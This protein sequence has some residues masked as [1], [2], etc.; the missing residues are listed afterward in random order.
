MEESRNSDAKKHSLKHRTEALAR[1]MAERGIYLAEAM[2]EFEKS[3][4]SVALEMSQHN[5]CK[6]AKIL[7]L[8]RNTLQSK[9]R[10][11]G[12]NNHKGPGEK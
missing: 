12:L 2:K 7:G 4:V 3:F 5:Q 6:A 1:E 11:F 9:V 8:H 10:T